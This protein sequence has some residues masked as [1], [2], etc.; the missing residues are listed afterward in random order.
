LVARDIHGLFR[1]RVCDVTSTGTR[2]WL[3]TAAE[4][5]AT[6][7]VVVDA[8]QVYVTG[9][10]NVGITG[11]LCVIA[12]DRTT[13]VLPWRTDKK[14]TDATG[15]QVFGWTWRPTAARPATTVLMPEDYRKEVLKGAAESDLEPAPRLELGTC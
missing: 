5:I 9:E 15:A 11:Y 12:Y 10:G 7:D 8:A 3:V 14:A 13:G 1:Q 2:K 4:G 6:R